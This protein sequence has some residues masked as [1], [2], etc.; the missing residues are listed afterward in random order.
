MT[1]FMVKNRCLLIPSGVY[2]CVPKCSV[3][4]V[5]SEF[6]ALG[7]Y[8]LTVYHERQR[9]NPLVMY[10]PSPISST[11]RKTSF[12]PFFD[13]HP[14]LQI[15]H[16]CRFTLLCLF[17]YYLILKYYDCD[18]SLEQFNKCLFPPIC[19]AFYIPKLSGRTV[20]LSQHG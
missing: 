14:N 9:F 20:I 11:H 16:L 10:Q 4:M 2:L 6:S 17:N 12:S 15:N 13:S 19:L 8:L 5:H 7:E 18:F 1:R 3:Y